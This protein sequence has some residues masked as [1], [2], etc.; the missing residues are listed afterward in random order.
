MGLT[1]DLCL[2][3]DCLWESTCGDG[4]GSS[5]RPLS[6]IL[7]K[8]TSLNGRSVGSALDLHWSQGVAKDVKPRIEQAVGVGLRPMA[9][10]AILVI[11]R[12][13]II[14]SSASSAAWGKDAEMVLLRELG[15]LSDDRSR[16]E[17]VERSFNRGI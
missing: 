6:A 4:R 16:F 13:G 12:R 14:S 17:E 9:I 8:A 11:R 2:G 10:S 15:P 5:D 7:V 1:L 3:V